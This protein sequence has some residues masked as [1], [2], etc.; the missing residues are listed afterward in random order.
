MENRDMLLDRNE[1]IRFKKRHANL[2]TSLLKTTHFTKEEIESLFMI[3]CKLQQ[4]G[5]V[6]FERY[7]TITTIRGHP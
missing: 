2:L 7:G 3:F 6:D 1:Q 4:L 5:A